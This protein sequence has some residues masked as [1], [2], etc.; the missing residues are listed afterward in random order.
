MKNSAI[1]IGTRIKPNPWNS[2]SRPITAKASDTP[3]IRRRA[4]D[5][6]IVKARKKRLRVLDGALVPRQ[7]FELRGV[8]AAGEEPVGLR[9]LAR[10][11]LAQFLGREVVGVTRE[12]LFGH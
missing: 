4:G 6:R 10:E 5:R 1:G 11:Q 3:Y 8:D 9:R 12:E 2:C 7:A